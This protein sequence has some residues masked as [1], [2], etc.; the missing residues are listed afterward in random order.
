M[1]SKRQSSNNILGFFKKWKKLG[2]G[3]VTGT[4]DDDP[5]GIATYSQ[6]GA[7]YNFQLLWL[8]LLTLPLMYIAQEMCARLGMVTGKGIAE[9]IRQHYSRRIL[10]PIVILLFLANTFN[11]GA[12]LAAMA[13]S[14]QLLIPQINFIIYVIAFTAICTLLQILTSYQTYSKYLK[15]LTLVLFSYIITGVMVKPDWAKVLIDT[16]IPTLTFNK[17][18]LILI[19]AILGT[20]ISPYLFFWQAAQEIE[21][22]IKQGKKTIKAR[23]HNNRKEIKGMQ[24][25]VLVGMVVS[26]IIMFFIIVV[27]GAT[28]FHHGITQIESAADAASALRPLAGP[29]AEL[30]FTTGIIGTGLLAIPVLA[31]SSAYAIGEFF[32]FKTGLYRKWVSAKGFYSIILLSMLIAIG[33]AFS[34]INPI[35]ALIYSAVANAILA[36]VVLF[37]IIS[38]TKN[39][40]I[41]GKFRNNIGRTLTGWLLLIIMAISGCAAIISLFIK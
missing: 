11:I 28:L 19:C 36:P 12:D 25:D 3:L 24:F 22:K 2:P 1:S 4:A 27:G 33:I 18:Q 38:L 16:L 21:E 29:W 14:F 35:K 40:Q 15:Y 20:T 10:F 8:S 31:G 13:A 7:Q 34:G 9:N 41:M 32:Y 30:L 6:A 37:F 39:V 26:N 5:A 17:D 23:S